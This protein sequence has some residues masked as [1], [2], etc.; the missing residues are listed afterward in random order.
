[1]CQEDTVI[2]NICAPTKNTSKYTKQK[3][4]KLI[5]ETDKSATTVVDFNTPDSANELLDRKSVRI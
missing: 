1:M 4:I 3:I 2:L 5:G